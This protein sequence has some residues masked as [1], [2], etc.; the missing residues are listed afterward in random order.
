[1]A[2]T[3]PPGVECADRP[4]FHLFFPDAS[5]GRRQKVDGA[6]GSR[7]EG[8]SGT[9]G[10]RKNRNQI[11]AYRTAFEGTMLVTSAICR[12]C[13]FVQSGLEWIIFLNEVKLDLQKTEKK[14][15][16]VT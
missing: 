8:Y 13:E 7:F 11:R 14:S 6:E 2:K 5:H 12:L 16:R 4:S 1:M 10:V 15:A 9:T 3:A